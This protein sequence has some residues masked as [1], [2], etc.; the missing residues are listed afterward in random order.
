VAPLTTHSVQPHS[1]LKPRHDK[2]YIT[3]PL[4][5]QGIKASISDL[6]HKM[7][8]AFPN[9]RW[10]SNRDNYAYKREGPALRVSGG[11]GRAG[12]S[13]RQAGMWASPPCGNSA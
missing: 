1:K 7:D 12:T 8:K 6:Q 13:G 3:A 11:A 4:L 10:G 2:Q 5:L 9:A